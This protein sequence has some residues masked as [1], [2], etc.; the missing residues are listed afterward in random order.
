M[1][2]LC[3]DSV[4]AACTYHRTAVHA[5]PWTTLLR[6]PPKLE[7]N[8]WT[9]RSAH[10]ANSTTAKHMHAVMQQEFCTL[11]QHAQLRRRTCAKRICA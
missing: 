6:I 2:N 10:Y 11:R 1:S 8:P 9:A 5:R 3:Q 7:K 4:S